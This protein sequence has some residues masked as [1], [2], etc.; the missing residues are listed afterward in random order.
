[1]G[2]TEFVIVAFR[3]CFGTSVRR[4][5]SFCWIRSEMES[6]CALCGKKDPPLKCASCKVAF[7]CGRECQVA[8][9]SEHKDDCRMVKKALA[10]VD[11]AKKSVSAEFQRDG[12]DVFRDEVGHFWGLFET[13][14]YMRRRHDHFVAL[15]QIDTYPAIQEALVQ[16]R[17]MLR[18]CRS[19]NM[20]VRKLMVP[21]FLRLGTFKGMQDCYDF[22]KWWLTC[23]PD[24]HYDWGNTSLPY[25]NIVGADVLEP[26]YSKLVGKYGDL[27]NSVGV[28]VIKM[29]LLFQLNEFCAQFGILILSTAS[30]ASFL[31]K[32]RGNLGA[33]GTVAAFL[34]PSYPCFANKRVTQLL[35]LQETLRHQVHTLLEHIEKHQ[36]KRIWKALV[37]PTKVM[38]APIPSY[39]SPGSA[40]EVIEV[41]TLFLPIF[42]AHRAEARG[43]RQM[44]VE[45][46]GERPDYDLPLMKLFY[47]L[48]IRSETS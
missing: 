35:A 6:S 42:T 26:L 47:I 15:N 24:G 31:H 34:R 30:A 18:L 1:M 32:F 3:L 48:G 27:H 38:Q 5:E 10:A 43:I 40:E 41:V 21:L 4:S 29:R 44:L 12:I 28:T 37:N 36:N 13:R 22:V 11:K 33:L 45:K 39:M 7:Y 8:H 19:D 25:L 17:D 16:G 9:H 23:D 20:G 14:P 2:V 46:V